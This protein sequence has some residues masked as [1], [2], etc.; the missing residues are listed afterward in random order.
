MQFTSSSR[1]RAEE[2][3]ALYRTT[4][5]NSEGA[6]E[7]Q[8]IGKLVEDILSTTAENDMFA[9]SAIKDG[10]IVGAIIFTR[11]TFAEDER[12]VFL[13]SPVA[14]ATSHQG[15]GLGQELL[16]HGLDHLRENGVDIALTYGD[17]NFYARVGF[18]QI[19]ED[20]ASAP[21]PLQYPQGWL[22][23][24]L[25]GQDFTPLKG[26]STCVPAFDNPQ[27]W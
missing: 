12:T 23:Q 13:L 19:S 2:L 18:A 1:D 16:R 5:T 14:V 11:M 4:F 26:A 8:L 10:Q 22:G 20:I 7:G 17:I 6:E 15:K 24:S 9:F 3:A 21:Q 27:Y 25:D